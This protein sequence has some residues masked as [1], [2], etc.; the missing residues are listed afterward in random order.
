MK[1]NT[2]G[3]KTTRKKVIRSESGEV[4]VHF[5][6]SIKQ[7]LNYQSAEV[8]I[9]IT[10]P[11]ENSDRAIRKGFRR[12]E[13]LIEAPLVSKFREQQELLGKLKA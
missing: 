5:S 10:L 11:V 6:Q 8:N 13:R 9:G 3:Q 1:L 2:T 4:L 7:S 12:A